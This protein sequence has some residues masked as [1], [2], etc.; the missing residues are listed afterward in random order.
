MTSRMS[1]GSSRFERAVE[2]T[3][4]QNITVNCRRSAASVDEG[5]KEGLGGFGAVSVAQTLAIALSRR[6]R[7]PRVT[8]SFS[9]SSPVRSTRTSGPIELSRNAV[10]YRPRLRLRS[11]TPMSMVAFKIPTSYDRRAKLDDVTTPRQVSDYRGETKPA[12]A[13]LSSTES[14]A[15]ERSH[16]RGRGSRIDERHG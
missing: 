15:D 3:R 6:L 1:S 13:H 16:V 11:Q 8:P 10:S 12:A 5:L 7:S 9:R 2:P 4:S 14:C